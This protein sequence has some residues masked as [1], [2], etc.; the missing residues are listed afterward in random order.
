MLAQDTIGSLLIANAVYMLRLDFRMRLAAF[1]LAG[2]FGVGL[3]PISEQPAGRVALTYCV[4]LKAIKPPSYNGRAQH[5]CWQELCAGDGAHPS[6]WCGCRIAPR[7]GR[8]QRLVG[9]RFI[10]ICPMGN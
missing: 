2:A 3:G 4:T 7:H 1:V 10:R 5:G 8:G 9:S 6:R